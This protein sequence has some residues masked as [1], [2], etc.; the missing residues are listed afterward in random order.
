[1][2]RI[3]KLAGA[4]TK[5]IDLIPG[6]VD[7]CRECR[8][9]AS[10]RPDV[11]PAVEL[12]TAKIEDFEWNTIDYKNLERFN[13]DLCYRGHAS[14]I[15]ERRQSF[16]R[17]AMHTVEEQPILM[18]DPMTIET[19]P[20]T[21]AGNLV[22]MYSGASHCNALLGQQPAVL[23][24]SNGTLDTDEAY[25]EYLGWQLKKAMKQIV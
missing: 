8:V 23:C 6:L 24:Y 4:P 5:S 20:C 15:D 7:T 14:S 2:E 3:L 10:P 12:T 13:S 19:L 22:M 11:A 16:M 21:F 1:M 25:I 18:S 9:W 17:P